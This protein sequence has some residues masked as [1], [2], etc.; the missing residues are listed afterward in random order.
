MNVYQM[1]EHRAFDT[2]GGFWVKRRTWGNSVALITDFDELNGYPPYFNNPQVRCDIYYD[3]GAT[4]VRYKKN[5]ILSCPGT[6]AYTRIQ[7]PKWWIDGK[8]C[9]DYAA[10]S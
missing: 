4:G 9:D 1:I 5:E 7:P 2:P 10:K 8:H 3:R 6:S